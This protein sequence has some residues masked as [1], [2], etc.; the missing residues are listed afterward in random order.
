MSQI[1][2]K[3]MLLPAEARTLLG[4]SKST[5]QR[6]SKKGVLTPSTTRG[7]HRRYPKKMILD[8]IDKKNTTTV[9]GDPGTQAT[10]AV[11]PQPVHPQPAQ[12]PIDLETIKRAVNE[13]IGGQCDLL[14]S[15]RKDVANLKSET[16]EIADL[17]SKIDGLPDSITMK[18]SDD[19]SGL[20]KQM[21]AAMAEMRKEARKKPEPAPREEVKKAEAKSVPDASE[22]PDALETAIPLDQ[23]IEDPSTRKEVLDILKDAAEKDVK[24]KQELIGLVA[25]CQ[26]GDN[27]ACEILGEREMPFSLFTSSNPLKE[28]LFG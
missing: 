19:I 6:W 14:N 3:E 1:P 9:T 15:L 22:K 10:L 8:F 28:K 12:P 27:E 17:K 11:Q 7:G 4:V 26:A 25:K 13:C 20:A 23:A 21:L 18:T 5:L 24:F 2:E 16:K